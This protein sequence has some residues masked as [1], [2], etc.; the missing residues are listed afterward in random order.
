MSAMRRILERYGFDLP[1]LTVGELYSLFKFC[2]GLDTLAG[3]CV[4]ASDQLSQW[5]MLSDGLNCNGVST[6]RRA[7]SLHS[8]ADLHSFCGLCGEQRHAGAG[9]SD[10]PGCSRI[11]V[12]DGQAAEA[13]TCRSVEQ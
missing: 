8:L 6:G 10:V 9:G 11:P 1:P 5:Q 12:E 7:I 2:D 3:N 4:F 13:A